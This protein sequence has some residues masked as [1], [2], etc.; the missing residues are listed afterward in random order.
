VQ[1]SISGSADEEATMTM[2]KRYTRPKLTRLGLLRRLT[3][4]TF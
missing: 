2:K 1:P 4:F 3:R